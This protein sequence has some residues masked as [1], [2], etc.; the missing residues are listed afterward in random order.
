MDDVGAV[1]VES[2]GGRE[3]EAQ[4]EAEAGS[5]EEDVVVV[6]GGDERLVEDERG[7][8]CGGELGV[9]E[10]EGGVAVAFRERDVEGPLEEADVGGGLG[11][12]REGES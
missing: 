1:V 9:V 5:G 8:G 11:E 6:G 3:G 4:G 10:V 7:V 2:G 12:E